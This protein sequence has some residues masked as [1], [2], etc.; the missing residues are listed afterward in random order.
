MNPEEITK[1]LANAKKY[2][3][4]LQHP[5]WQ[6]RRMTILNRDQFTCQKCG[7]KE[8]N[9]HVH[10]K[11]Y[12]GEP[13]EAPDNDLETLCKDCHKVITVINRGIS[14][15]VKS[16]L[17]VTRSEFEKM[18][19]AKMENGTVFIMNVQANDVNILS[20]LPNELEPLTKAING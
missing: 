11:K 19:V 8:T 10:H 6:Q 16:I 20:F 13:W 9:L 1:R 7:D 17:K 3:E 12:S 4:K 15:E 2:S 5:L 18:F 14:G